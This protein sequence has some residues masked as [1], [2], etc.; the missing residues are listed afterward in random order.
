[1]TQ[2]AISVEVGRSQREV[3]RLIEP[4][5]VRNDRTWLTAAEHP[6]CMAAERATG[7][8][9]VS[10][11]LVR[12]MSGP[13]CSGSARSVSDNT[14]AHRALGSARRGTH[15]MVVGHEVRSA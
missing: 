15:Q 8:S 14:E 9:D 3:A 11:R 5:R 1:M 13:S 4:A 10:L 2:R 12:A 6:Q 7:D